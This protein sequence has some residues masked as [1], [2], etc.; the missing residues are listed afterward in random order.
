VSFQFDVTPAL[1]GKRLDAAVAEVEGDLSRTQ[2][3]RMIGSGSVRVSGARVKPAHRL[4]LGEHVEGTVPPPEPC[5]LA[6]EAIPLDVVYED[7]SVIVVDKPAG[8]VVHPAAGHRAGTLV[9]ALLHHC[10]DLQGVGDALRPG[11]VHRLDKDTSGLIVAAKTHAAHRSLVAQ[12]QAH[13]VDREYLALVRGAPKEQSGSIDAPIGRHPSDRKRYTADGRL[14]RRSRV[15]RRA[16]THWRVERR[17]GELTLLRVRLE[18]GRTHQI[19]VHLASVGL[20]VA[21]DPVYGGGR[22]AA[23]RLGLRRQALHAA[24]L[25]FDHPVSGQRLLFESG[26]PDDLERVVRG[27]AD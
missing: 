26:L 18:T 14:T 22:R 24:R 9:H 8:L 5:E 23:A 10:A 25:G 6:P 17:L 20:P 1:V 12:F 7:S 3:R 11:I 4:R 13:T 16:V 21:G 2:I 15:A 27:C 19:R